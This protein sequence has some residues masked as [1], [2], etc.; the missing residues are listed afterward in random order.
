LEPFLS[1]QLGGI[2][3]P[4]HVLTIKFRNRQRL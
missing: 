4:C 3:A 2:D 1:D